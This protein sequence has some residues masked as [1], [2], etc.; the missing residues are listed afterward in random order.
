MIQKKINLTR[1]FFDRDALKV[2]QDLLGKVIRVRYQT[3]WLCAQIIETEA[4][5]IHEKASHASLG[6]TEKR[7]AL[8]MP[9]GTIY[10]Y[11]AQGGDSLNISCHGEGNSVLIKSAVP[12]EGVKNFK[13]MV[14]IMQQLNPC[15]N[16]PEYRKPKHLCAGQ[17]LLCKSLNLRV[18]DWDQ[19]NFSPQRFIITDQG[20]Y[21]GKIIQ[22][23]RLG[24]PK[25]RDED[26]LY[27]F[28]DHDYSHC[29]TK[30]PL[31]KRKWQVGKDY[32]IIKI[33]SPVIDQRSMKCSD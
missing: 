24:I 23:R 11:Y 25:G 7:K 29:C 1:N 2:A 31:S 12:Y 9:A 10:M 30:N 4:Y 19:K 21:P 13:L 28:V 27:R 32:F 6:F 15:K 22:T 26:L 3:V 5:Y 8:F 14:G 16:K 20:Y 33:N 17:T 18:K